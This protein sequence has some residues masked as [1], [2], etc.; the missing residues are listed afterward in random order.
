MTAS[1][2]VLQVLVLVS[3]VQAPPSCWVAAGC[4]LVVVRT[5]MSPEVSGRA[6]HWACVLARG[7][8]DAVAV[9]E[10]VAKRP[11]AAGRSVLEAPPQPA[12]AAVTAS[13]TVRPATGHGEIEVREV[14]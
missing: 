1:T 3:Q 13:V 4:P 7:S 10:G 6:S 11:A 9:P 12:S 5:R 2:A 8:A 14:T